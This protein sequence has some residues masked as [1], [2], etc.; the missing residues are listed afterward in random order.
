MEQNR[1]S[2]KGSNI[3]EHLSLTKIAYQIGKAWA[4][5]ITVITDNC[6]G[7]EGKKNSICIFDNYP[8]AG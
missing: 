2:I 7:L 5:K 8:T 6:A 4:F 3:H 1:N